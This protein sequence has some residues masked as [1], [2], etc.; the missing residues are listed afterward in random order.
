MLKKINEGGVESDSG[1]SMQIVHPE[2]LEYREGQRCISIS[3]G[4]DSQ[5][6][7]AYIYV[8]NVKELSEIDKKKVI[9]NLK[10]AVKLLKGN[11]EVV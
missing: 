7:K 8:S 5:S 6:R 10:A 9:S 4:Y 11:F 2:Y 3:M 1:F